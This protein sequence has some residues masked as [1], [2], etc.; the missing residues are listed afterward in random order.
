L[1]KERLRQLAKNSL[2]SFTEFTYPRYE[3][4]DLH[5][6]IAEQLER[7]ERGEIDR[8]MLLVPPRHGKSELAS[9]R[10]PAF[11]LGLHPERHFISA[12]ASAT[13]AEDFGRDVRNLIAG[14]EYAQVFETRLAEDSQAKGRWMTSEG[15][16]YYACGVGS[17]LMGRGAHVFLIDD[18][19]GS[20]AD[21][22]SEV[23]RKAV[24]SWYQ[25]TVYNRLEKNG[26]IVLINHR[27]HHAD[28]SGML[29]DQQAAGGDRWEV[30]E[31]KAFSDSGEAL[32]PE[33]FDADALERIKRNTTAQDWSALYQQEPTPDE[34]AFFKAEWLRPVL[35]VPTHM[36]Y[37]GASDLAVTTD[38][39]D[40]T[41]H[42]ILGVDAKG[43]TFLVDLW[44]KQASS[45]EWVESYCDLVLKWK[46]HHWAHEK[47][48]IIS[49]VGPF[50]AQRA[51]ERK[52]WTATE[53]FP[54]RGDKGV[55]CQSIR[56]RMELSGLYVPADASWLPDLRVEL[57]QFPFGAHDD[58]CD[59]LGLA[60]QLLDKH[61]KARKPLPDPEEKNFDDYQPKV[62]DL[63]TNSFMTM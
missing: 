51:L 59:A 41:V 42:V 37:Y 60:G 21:A 34:G 6:Q 47:T 36:N 13:L 44:R 12:S 55:R 62:S 32:W 2:I 16:S 50:L 9:R 14:Q 18:P 11:Y 63:L 10:F 22:R 5:R 39:G 4:A 56:G 15:G 25:G 38:G 53:T 57:V 49:G 52:A 29:L 20:M 35:D 24:H 33:K 46:P 1:E 26:A 27:M 8:L 30:V 3:T 19:F 31:L 23:E 43:R 48:S 7:V 40:F 61:V 17:A 45:G 54:T 58:Q 28:L